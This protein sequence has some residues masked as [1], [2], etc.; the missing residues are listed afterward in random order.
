MSVTEAAIVVQAAGNAGAVA[1]LARVSKRTARRWC[2]GSA[3][4]PADTLLHLAR[5]SAAVRE[6]LLR[7]LALD[8]AACLARL[9]RLE[10][11]LAALRARRAAPIRPPHPVPH[12]APIAPQE[13]SPDALAHPEPAGCPAA[14]P[15][16]AVRPRGLG[17]G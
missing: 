9:D 2:D 7:A 12:P 15:G 1:R 13:H 17:H 16:A 11:D 14:Q 5:R 4:V 10:A 3:R 6:A 8:E